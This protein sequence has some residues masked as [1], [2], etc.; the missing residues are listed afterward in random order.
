MIKCAQHVLVHPPGTY[1]AVVRNPGDPNYN[2]AQTVK[3]SPIIFNAA[4]LVRCKVAS[5]VV[6]YH[7]MC[8]QQVTEQNMKWCIIQHIN[9]VHGAN[10]TA[11]KQLEISR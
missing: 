1:I 5:V 4:F 3:S 8:G 7:L 10:R 2:I 9:Y 6:W 11:K